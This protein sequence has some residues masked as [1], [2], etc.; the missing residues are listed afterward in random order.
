MKWLFLSRLAV[1]NL[2][3]KRLR[4]GLTVGGI[5]LS[6]GVMVF[7]LGLGTGLQ[8]IVTTEIAQSGS[9]QTISVT[10]KRTKQLKL[11]SSALSRLSSISG[12]SSLEQQ[13]GL[14]GRVTYH[15]ISLDM[16]VYA[17]SKGF[18]DTTTYQLVAGEIFTAQSATEKQLIISTR[19]LQALGLTNAKEAV[20]KRVDFT[21]T[22]N[23][24]W[25]TNQAE[26]SKDFADKNFTII[27][28]VEKG[29]TPV[30]YAPLEFLQQYG[31]N[32][33]SE[34]A[35]TVT[36]PD[37]ISA[38][39][40]TVEQMGFQTASIRDTIDQVNRIFGV[41][42]TILIIFGAITLVIAVF[43]TLNTITI[44]LVE[45]TRQV[46]FLRILG[47]SKQDVR[48]LFMLQSILLSFSGVVL[49]IGLGI[50]L[51]SICNGLVWYMAKQSGVAA[52]QLYQLPYVAILLLLV[53][54]AGLGW[55]LGLGPARR[56]V[57]L[58]PLEALR[59]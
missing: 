6:V 12:V 47:I 13:V 22:V 43:G 48:R 11:D 40:E 26:A 44:A 23:K 16:P 56:A 19:A 14:S 5:A 27:G 57:G 35:L 51:G 7:L 31:I 59:V 49:G 46:G 3:N 21:I 55:L 36:V 25:A 32:A 52:W 17:V 24:D 28:V 58:R 2:L 42:Q 38:V 29:S 53:C 8:R 50:G 1:G 54:A 10:S 20:G 30:T 41:I 4:T 34:V 45:Q 9:Q 33:A 37:K 15:G 39:R 18:L